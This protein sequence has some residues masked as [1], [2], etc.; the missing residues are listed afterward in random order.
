MA[1]AKIMMYHT[2]QEA[3]LAFYDAMERNDIDTMM[4]VW[5]ESDSI[6]C[7]HPGASRLQGVGEIR[8]GFSQ[9]F[10][11]PSPMMDFTLSDMR[12][13]TVGELAI[14]TVREEI[15]IDG[16]LASV[17]LATNIY[18]NTASGWRIILHHASPE[19]DVEVDDFDFTLDNAVPPMLLH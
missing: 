6:V 16:Q 4:G 5:L 14:H 13:Q 1:S 19:L 18:Q 2:P 11:E 17:M 8:A 15:L 3:E 7:V 10:E 12:C 9:I